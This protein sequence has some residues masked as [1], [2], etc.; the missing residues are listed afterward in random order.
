M[1]KY[2]R[3]PHKRDCKNTPIRLNMKHLN[4]ILLKVN[5]KCANSTRILNFAYMAGINKVIIVGNLGKDPETRYTTNNIAV[6]SL[7]VATSETYN[8]K[9]TGEK[10]T[11]TEW[12][13][14]ILWRGLAETAERFLRKG[15]Q[16]YIEGKLRT[17][18]W[19][20]KQG[21]THYS[22]EIVGDNMQM[23]DKKSDNT[24]PI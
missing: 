24:L 2:H 9:T 14:I 7:S 1:T 15:S 18:E 6:S 22:T 8:D 13:K 10:T 4:D 11:R 16:V 19:E 3:V 23:L 5:E 21:I 20:D 12:H 17:K